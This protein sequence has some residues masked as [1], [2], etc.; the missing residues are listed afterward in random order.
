M[1][2]IRKGQAFVKI[3]DGIKCLCP[4]CK[5]SLI[6]IDGLMPLLR[7]TDIVVCNCG[8]DVSDIMR[9]LAGTDMKEPPSFWGKGTTTLIEQDE[10]HE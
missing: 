5:V 8:Y 6:T 9:L 7:E 10:N 3:V 4:Q 2:T 1:I